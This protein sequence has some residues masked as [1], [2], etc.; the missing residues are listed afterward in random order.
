MASRCARPVTASTHPATEPAPSA[1]RGSG[2]SITACAPRAPPATASATPSAD[3]TAACVPNLSRSWVPL[4]RTGP[5]AILE[6]VRRSEGR[7]VVFKALATGSGP[8]THETLDCMRPVRTVRSLR[9]ALTAGGALT[10]RDERLAEL[11]TWLAKTLARVQETTE[12]RMLRSYISWHHLRR[13]RKN[14]PDQLSTN[15]QP[16]T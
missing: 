6:W 14:H 2:C 11:Q 5:N 12:R 9:A 13:L 10:A 15:S 7:R 4:L 3:L 16:N 1:G 8:V